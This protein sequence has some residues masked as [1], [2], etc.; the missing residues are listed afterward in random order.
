MQQDMMKEKQALPLVS[1]YGAYENRSIVTK[2][3]NRCKNSLRADTEKGD[4]FFF[5][6]LF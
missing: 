1:R 6:I 4:N 5:C 3:V 2:F